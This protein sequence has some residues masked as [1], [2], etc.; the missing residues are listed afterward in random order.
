MMYLLSGIVK[1]E[2]KIDRQ[3]GGSGE[4]AH[5]MLICR[6]AANPEEVVFR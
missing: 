6:A 3:D 2:C 5:I 4:E 1:P